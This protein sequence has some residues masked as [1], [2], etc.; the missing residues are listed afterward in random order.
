MEFGTIKKI[1]QLMITIGLTIFDMVSDIILAADY[2]NTGEDDWWFALTLTF[3][4]LPLIPLFFLLLLTVLEYIGH[5][6]SLSNMNQINKEVAKYFHIWKQFECVAE[7]GP[8]LILQLYI[9]AISSMDENATD[10]IG[11]DA[12]NTTQINNTI[13]PEDITIG[14]F[15]SSF[16]PTVNTSVHPSTNPVNE[17]SNIDEAFTLLLQILVII[18]ALFSQSWS[19]VSS[20]C[21]STK[22]LVC[23]TNYISSGNFNFVLWPSHIG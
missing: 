3:F 4:V 13:M 19:S 2:A 23:W 16:N 15:Y 12:E 5:G 10:D 6:C 9:L 14:S 17:I 20:V 8:Q 7:S 21:F 22:I 1:I 18:S 11:L